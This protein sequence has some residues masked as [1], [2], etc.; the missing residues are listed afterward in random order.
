MGILVDKQDLLDAVNDLQKQVARAE[1]GGY[2]YSPM[3]VP[4]VKRLLAEF[5][6]AG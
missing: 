6:V 2:G 1:A 5:E 3:Y 4:S